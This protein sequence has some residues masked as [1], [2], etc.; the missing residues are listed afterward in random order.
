MVARRSSADAASQSTN[1][2]GIRS[3]PERRPADQPT[4]RPVANAVPPAGR[5]PLRWGSRRSARLEVD[6]LGASFLERAVESSLDGHLGFEPFDETV[7]ARPG[8]PYGR[9]EK[10][11][12]SG[13]SD[14]V[15]LTLRQSGRRVH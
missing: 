14:V 2:P 11:A 3:V 1:G 13:P 8:V 7:G 4:S 6:D 10:P 12:V 15:G 9:D 5:A